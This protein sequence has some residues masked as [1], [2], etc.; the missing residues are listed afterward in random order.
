MIITQSSN[1]INGKDLINVG[2][3]TAI[4]LVIMMIIMPIGFIPVL[5][6]LYCVF[7][8]LICGT[9]WMLFITKV[10]KFGMVLIMS[11]LLGLVLMLTG[12]GWYALPLCLISGLLA[13]LILKKGNYKSS[14]LDIIAYGVFS[15][16]CFGSFVPLIFMAD[17]YWSDNASYGEDFIS[18]AK[19]V[20]QLWTAPV[21]ILSCFLFGLLGGWIGLKLM[22]KHF[23]KS[24]IV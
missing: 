23:V 6:P 7:I 20:F 15:I 9:P 4:I 19:Q 5:M 12:M 17:K 21:L 18:S 8:P 11:I 1:R 14:K 2:I 10:N 13:E 24:G 16:W 22:K 3:F